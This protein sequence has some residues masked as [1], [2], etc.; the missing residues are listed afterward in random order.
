M[1]ITGTVHHVGQTEV[2]SDK[3]SK[4]LLVVKTDSE[5]NSLCPI[6]FTKDKTAL[7]D[8]LQIGQSVSVEVNCGGR[9]W[10]GKYFASI[11]GW[12][13]TAQARMESRV[14]TAPIVTQAPQQVADPEDSDLPF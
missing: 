11:T 10:Q 4:R 12:K 5:Y 1:T 2:I 7:L 8:G 13:L 14:A 6:E 3:F 9:E